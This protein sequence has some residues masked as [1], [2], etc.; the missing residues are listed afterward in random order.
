[1]DRISICCA[2]FLALLLLLVLVEGAAQ[3]RFTHIGY[4]N[5][6]HFVFY[7]RQL[8]PISLGIYSSHPNITAVTEMYASPNRIVNGVRIPC[9]RA[10][11]QAAINLDGFYLCGG[12]ILNRC[13]ILTAAH[14]VTESGR[15]T[16]RVGSAQHRRGGQLRDVAFV[17]V[18]AKYNN[19]TMQNDIALMRLK[20]PLRYGRCVEQAR[21]PTG[22]R[23]PQYNFL[24]GTQPDCY[25]VSGFGL[26]SANSANVPRYLRATRVC[27]VPQ[28]R[29][30][31]MNAKANVRIYPQM[32]CAYRRG[33][34]DSCIGDSGG[35]LVSDRREIIG[36]VSFGIGCGDPKYPGIYT[37]VAHYTRWIR[38]AVRRYPSC[39]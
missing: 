32:I 33:G 7:P 26:V 5:G 28:S 23:R 36:I 34:H 35:P 13:W 27:E 3:D 24:L 8:N 38:R 31:L 18:H 1:M 9:T 6:T 10:P 25:L 30:Q 19:F 4:D 2:I 22:R 16:V 17:V 29:C 11:Y 39:L 14:C 37:R 15:Y 12:T 21:L 20:R